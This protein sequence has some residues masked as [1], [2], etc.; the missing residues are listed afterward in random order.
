M[1]FFAVNVGSYLIGSNLVGILSDK[2]GSTAEPKML[3]YA[4]LVCP[5]ACVAGAVLLFV[6][7]RKMKAS[8]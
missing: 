8:A 4:L 3:S 1:F 6:G 7:N 2:F 5:A